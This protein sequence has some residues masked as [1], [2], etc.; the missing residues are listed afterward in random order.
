VLAPTTNTPSVGLLYRYY[1][2]VEIS[3]GVV[4]VGAMLLIDANA[5]SMYVSFKKCS[6][7]LRPATLCFLLLYQSERYRKLSRVEG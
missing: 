2:V 7:L 4:E 5:T 6:S 1:Q 3:T